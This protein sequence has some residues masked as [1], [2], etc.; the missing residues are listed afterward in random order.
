MS[1]WPGSNDYT[2]AIQSPSTCFRDADLKHSLLE[3]NKLTRMPKVW[4]GNFAQVYELRNSSSRWAVK[5]FTRSA[6][7]IRARYS[8]I[9]QAIATTRLP[10]FVDFRFLD[11][12]ILV[13]GK[14]Y[15][16]V[17]MQ[18]VEGQA[19]DK[20]VEANLYRPQVLL[21][22][23]ARIAELVSDLEQHQ[24][25]H[26]DLQHGNIVLTNTSIKLVD[27]DG[28]YIPAFSGQMA[29]E[30]GLP[31][32]QHPRRAASDYSIGLD[33]F[34]LVVLC[35][36]LCA[37]AVEPVLWHE[38]N[39]GDNMLFTAAD[40]RNPAGSKIL[41]R[42]RNSTVAQVKR[43]AE[44][45]LHACSQQPLAVALPVS[46]I[47][48]SVTQPTRWWVTAPQ[49]ESDKR[50]DG[51][52]HLHRGDAPE[53]FTAV[54][55]GHSPNH[56]RAATLL[57]VAVVAVVVTWSTN[58]FFGLSIAM[59]GA[60][61][62][63]IERHIA[64]ARL[65]VLGRQRELQRAIA[66]SRS[67]IAD[68][69]K[70]KKSA[71]RRLATLVQQ[72]TAERAQ[73]LK[74][75]H[76]T[77]RK[78]FQDKISQK[79]ATMTDAESRKRSAEQRLAS[80]NQLESTEAVQE[81]NRLQEAQIANYLSSIDI[82]GLTEI[83]GIGPHVVGNFRAAGIHNIGQ[84]RHRGPFAQ[85]VGAQRR[86]AIHEKIQEWERVA[87]RGLQ[88]LPA[89]TR[90]R[91]QAKYAAQRQTIMNEIAVLTQS[92]RVIGPEL[93]QAEGSLAQVGNHQ[94][95]SAT[96]ARIELKYASQRQT[97]TQEIG[98]CAQRIGSLSSEMRQ[99]EWNLKQVRIPTFTQF[100]KHSV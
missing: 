7:D 96:E 30:V 18:W 61:A 83:K 92:L 29:P 88:Q 53:M 55:A 73:E 85:G 97:A 75:L 82:S 47:S 50:V 72:E 67:A 13:N 39:T 60:L 95:S 63:F 54:T 86:L 33:R 5:C 20:Y 99:A 49:I 71:E 48:R 79:R 11:N 93:R 28:M 17:K 90:A 43:L 69:E 77:L 2:I 74:R 51:T 27:Y 98:A 45:L 56:W 14:R 23:A 91:I 76:D 21:D 37:L 25:A 59:S 62:L 57:V 40:F 6:S 87:T 52:A 15:P 42:L 4:T 36:A 100:V 81:L 9:A 78:E 24:L 94:L 66:E 22:A 58:F 26:G 89:P 1:E 46:Q 16:I 44:A 3:R 65:P 34:S 41:N 80:L 10:Y 64:Y 32:Y 35:T 70:R 68:A 8:R 31:S 19:L 38:F 12:E 84:L